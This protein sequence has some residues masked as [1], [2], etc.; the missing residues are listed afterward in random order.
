MPDAQRFWSWRNA[1][2]TRTLPVVPRDAPLS[3]K[4][5]LA[6][7]MNK[8]GKDA[9]GKAPGVLRRDGTWQGMPFTTTESTDE[10]M[11]VWG[12]WGASIGVKTGRGLILIDADTRDERLAEII[13]KSLENAFGKLPVRYGQWPKAGY[14]V[15]VNDEKL[16]YSQ[17]RFNPHVKGDARTHFD[18][19]EILSEGRQ[20]VAEGMHP[21]GVMY[22][23]PDGMPLYDNL[24]VL[25][26]G[27]LREVLT[28]LKAV[29]PKAEEIAFTAGDGSRENINQDAL[30]GPIDMVRAAVAAIPNIGDPSKPN[31]G[32]F[33]SRFDYVKVLTALKAATYEDPDAGLEIAL[34]WTSRWDGGENDADTVESDWRRIVPPF[35]IG[36]PWL[37]DKAQEMTG[38]HIA[39]QQ[40]FDAEVA[41]KAPEPRQRESIEVLS[42]DEIFD[43]PDPVFLIERHVV[44]KALGFIYGDP[45]TGKSFL[46]ID[47]ALSLASGLGTWHGDAMKPKSGV[48]VYLAGEGAPGFKARISAWCR[49]HG[50]DRSTLRGKFWLVPIRLSFMDPDA[51]KHMVAAVRKR[52]GD[53]PVDLLAVDT[54]SRV[55]PGADENIQKEM[56]LFV[57]ACAAVRDALGCAVV[58]VHHSNK[59]GGMR[60]SGVLGGAG[61]FVFKLTRKK[62]AT[63]GDLFCEKMKDGPD[64]WTDNYR[65]QEVGPG[66]GPG[67]MPLSLVPLRVGRAEAAAAKNAADGL[68]PDS[69]DLVLGAIKAAWDGG[70]PWSLHARSGDRYAVRKLCAMLDITR[71]KAADMMS[72]LASTGL[73]V[74]DLVS[75]DSKKKGLRVKASNAHP[76]PEEDLFG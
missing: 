49:Q 35:E 16:A 57:E 56:T 50:I 20:F 29:L 73:V 38:A 65:F 14:L 12:S 59:A 32:P 53:G 30:R 47:W 17:L 54:V 19:I 58:G 63:V 48:V 25:D 7:R 37:R 36:F 5:S 66:E 24:P 41:A 74:E 28:G 34:D 33:A 15:R 55:L 72:M 27:R 26:V 71:A 23:W 31:S 21:C 61:D 9:R 40:Y 2:F 45:G 18:A 42:I 68:T 8:G 70:N 69:T 4:S 1:G 62:G 64:G 6:L 3:D 13:R 67:G 76:T 43:L 60:G 75:T 44:E 10:D 52:V 11:D 46:A 22:D 51:V 39:A